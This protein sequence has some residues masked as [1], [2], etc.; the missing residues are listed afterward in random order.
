M[1]GKTR[2]EVQ[3][4]LAELRRKADLGLSTDLSHGLET[5]A[6]YLATWLEAGGTSTGPQTLN[7][8]RHI[9][10]DHVTPSLGRYKLG[11]LRPDAIQL[12]YATKL[13]EG[14]SPYTVRKIHIV[15]HRA[16][17]MAVRWRYL[18]RN[19]ADDVDPPP[20]TK[21]DVTPAEPAQL[22]RLVKAAD[23]AKD[24]LSALWTLAMY[25]G[26]R[27]GELLALG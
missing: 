8:Y 19:P 15:L 12:L 6:A 5:V 9:V 25:T 4:Q 27:Q 17:E 2:G 21:R 14:L 22:T 13:A 10:R 1:T 23:A 3:K 24:R 7:G 11:S 16:L 26:C 20:A 18:P